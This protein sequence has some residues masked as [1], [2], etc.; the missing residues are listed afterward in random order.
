MRVAVED[1]RRVIEEARSQSRYVVLGGHSLGG[2]IATAYATWDFGGQPGADDLSGLVYIDGGSGPPTLSADQASQA[3]QNLQ[4][5]SPWLAFGGIAPPFAGLFNLLGSTLA[6][7]APNDQ[8][9]L[10]GFPFIP[11]NLRAPFVVTNEAAYGY[12][13]DTQTSPPNLIAAQVHAGHLAAAGSPRGWDS[14]GELSPIQRVADMFSGTGV[15]GHDGTAW[16]HPQRLTIDSGAVGDGIANPAQS[17]LG[18]DSIHGRDLSLP[19]YA[20]G[21]ALGGQRVIDAARLLASQSGIPDGKLTLVNDSAT[22]AH[23][24]PLAAHPQNDFLS[25]LLPFLKQ[26]KAVKKHPAHGAHGGS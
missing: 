12:S 24:D 25:H 14:G 5:A 7:I 11:S 10:Q 1:L 15:L 20:F 9:I 23:V 21:A 26:V 4:S 22:Y 17:V 6:K 8:S 13:L 18:V 2:S 3:L 16:Y 19:I